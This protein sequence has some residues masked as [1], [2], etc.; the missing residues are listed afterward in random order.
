MERLY[1]I[2]IKHFIS[3]L[4]INPPPKHN[5]PYFFF[6]T[7]LFLG[8]WIFGYFGYFFYTNFTSLLY[9]TYILY[10]FLTYTTKKNIYID[11][12]VLP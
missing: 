7:I 11:I 4:A 1:I 2:P 10:N 3:I 6:Y 5:L 12:E 9:K 8:G